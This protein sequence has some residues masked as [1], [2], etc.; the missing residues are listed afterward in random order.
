MGAPCLSLMVSCGSMV[1]SIY[2]L[3]VS[4]ITLS[5]QTGVLGAIV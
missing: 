5:I 3:I 1:Q 2:E 4:L